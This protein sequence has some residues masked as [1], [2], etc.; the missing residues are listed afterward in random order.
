MAVKLK[1]TRL[2]SKKHPFYRVVAARDE[3]RRDG[4]PLEFLG[5]YDPMTNPA[6]VR[7]DADKIR[8]WLDRGA[9]P[10]STVRSLLKKHLA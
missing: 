7:L 1:L 4:R 8:A 10:T 3:T 6:D 2:G 5:F 9:E